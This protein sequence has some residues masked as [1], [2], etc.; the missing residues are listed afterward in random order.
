MSSVYTERL[1]GL[2][3]KLEK[4]NADAAL[5]TK[6]ENYMYM[7][8]FT[9]TAAML[10]I[11]KNKAILLTDFRYV[12][13][14][15]AQAPDYEIIRYNGSYTS[16]INMIIGNRS[17]T[18]L[19]FEDSYVTYRDYRQFKDNLN[20]SDMIPLGTSIEELRRVKDESEMTLIRKAVKIADNAFEHILGYLKPGV[21]EVEIAAEMEYF[22]KKQGATGASFD[23]IIASGLRSSMPHGVA[24]EKKLEAGD[25]ITMDYGALYKGYCSDITRT[26]FLGEPKADLKRIYQIVLDAQQKGIEAVKQGRRGKDVDKIARDYIAD[27]GFG[28]YFGHGLGHGVG[29]E[30]HEDP[31]LS[32]RG[33]IILQD[34]MIVTVEPG[35]YIPG[36]GGV[37]IEDM[38]LVK[39]QNAEDLTKAKKELIVI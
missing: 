22:M 1:V 5:I 13:Q 6:R 7:S 39:G 34:G 29:L 20:V 32:P 31:T 19:A 3:K 18:V 12:E 30:I 15:A 37:R 36:L 11:T 23:T 16:E 2:R 17:K 24:S 27:A 8:G 4:L 14:A 33:E 9:G 28:D 25:V 10:Y 26:V 21:T 38:L 35:I